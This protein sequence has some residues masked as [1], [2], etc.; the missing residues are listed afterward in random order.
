MANWKTWARTKMLRYTG[1]SREV[2][3]LL[4]LDEWTSWN[5]RRRSPS[6]ARSMVVWTRTVMTYRRQAID[7]GK[8]FVRVKISCREELQYTHLLPKRSSIY[9][10]LLLHGHYSR[11]RKCYTFLRIFPTVRVFAQI[12]LFLLKSG[13]GGLAIMWCSKCVSPNSVGLIL[14]D[15][16]KWLYVVVFKVHIV[17]FVLLGWELVGLRWEVGIVWIGVWWHFEK[18]M[19]WILRSTCERWRWGQSEIKESGRC[20]QSL[21]TVVKQTVTPIIVC[22]DQ[23]DHCHIGAALVPWPQVLTLMIVRKFQAKW[24]MINSCDSRS[25]LCLLFVYSDEK[26]TV[27]CDAKTTRIWILTWYFR[28]QLGIECAIA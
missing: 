28:G 24:F 10:L 21:S 16:V 25:P 3:L 22:L 11:R 18:R 2:K 6:I 1:I 19:A 20:T 8:T 9:F 17:C 12:R 7:S 13:H 14:G 4:E 23:L 5:R 27:G 26:R 15:F